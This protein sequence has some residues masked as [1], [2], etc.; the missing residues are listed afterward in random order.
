SYL[1][2]DFQPSRQLE[3]Q[4][5]REAT[6]IFMAS[7]HGGCSGHGLAMAAHR[8]GCDVELWAQSKSTPFIDSVRDPKKKDIIELV[9]LDFCQQLEEAAV[10]VVDAMPSVEQ[11][12]TWLK[13]GMCL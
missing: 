12:E 9:H 11:I 3:L 1:D 7:G 13:Q 4:L 2:P 6:T 8:R 10:P 5:W